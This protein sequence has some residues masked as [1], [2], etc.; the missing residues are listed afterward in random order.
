VFLCV[1]NYFQIILKKVAFL[2]G[3]NKQKVVSLYQAITLITLKQNIMTTLQNTSIK[4]VIS[5]TSFKPNSIEANLLLT[6]MNCGF[7]FIK[8]FKLAKA[9]TTN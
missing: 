2:F 1:V 6:G 9:L 3:R 5:K 8:S 7:S 4:N